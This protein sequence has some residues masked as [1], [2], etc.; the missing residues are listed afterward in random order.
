MARQ[1][2][3]TLNTI[4]LIYVSFFVALMLSIVPLPESMIWFQPAWVPLMFIFWSIEAPQF[5]GLGMAFLLGIFLDAL[6]GSVLGEHAAAMCIVAYLSIK[7][8]LLM[9][10]YPAVQQALNV[11]LMLFLYQLIIIWLHSMLGNISE[12][13]FFWLPAVTSMVFWPVIIWLMRWLRL[14]VRTRRSRSRRY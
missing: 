5:M 3:G 1:P 10:A 6:T 4:Y 8:H 14:P 13:W 11:F 7:F 2:N 12:A 9:R